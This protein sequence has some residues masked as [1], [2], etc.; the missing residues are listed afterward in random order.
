MNMKQVLKGC[1]AAALLALTTNV[2]AGPTIELKDGSR[3]EGEVLSIDHGVY[4]VRSPVLGTL[5]IT[6]E[7][8][9][10]IVYDGAASTAAGSPGNSSARGDA[11]TQD[12]QSLQKQL[13]QD[14]ATLQSIMSLQSDPQIQAILQDPAVLKAIQEGDYTSLLGNPK[15]RALEN[16]TQ[17]NQL[18]RQQVR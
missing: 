1:L 16:N 3:I 17:L 6:Q 8:I 14:P 10:Q 15:I 11:L 18:V 12:I 5:R 4:I 7:N 2:L 13:M 9:A